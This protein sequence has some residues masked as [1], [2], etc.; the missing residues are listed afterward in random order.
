MVSIYHITHIGNLES[1]IQ[2]EGLWCDN[3]V[4]QHR[5]GS[6][7]IAHGN[8]KSRRARTRVPVGAQ[9]TLADYV[10]FYFAP[11]SPMLYVISRGGVEGYTGDQDGILHLVSYAEYV[12]SQN[13]PFTFTDGHAIMIYSSFF[14]D[15]EDLDNVDWDIMQDRYWHDTAEDMDRKRRRQAEFLVHDFF[16]WSL[17]VEIGVMNDRIKEQVETILDNSEHRPEIAIRRNWYY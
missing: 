5:I 3:K 9:G 11:R 17:I 7:D 16:P 6:M 4:H 15:L 14:D 1:I 10:P 2:N 8:I 12:Q 13:I